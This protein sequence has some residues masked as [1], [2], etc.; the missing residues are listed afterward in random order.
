MIL[1][2]WHS[3]F[4]VVPDPVFLTFYFYGSPWSRVPLFLTF[5][6]CNGSWSCVPNILFLWWSLILCSFAFDFRGDPSFC[7]WEN[8]GRSVLIS[9]VVN[10]KVKKS[11]NESNNKYANLFKILWLIYLISSVMKAQQTYFWQFWNQNQKN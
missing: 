2:S 4:M 8:N 11:K 7:F 6:F 10:Q 5:Y 1:Y 3:I 9:I